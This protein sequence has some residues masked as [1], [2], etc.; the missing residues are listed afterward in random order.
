MQIANTNTGEFTP[1]LATESM[2]SS[3]SLLQSHMDVDNDNLAYIIHFQHGVNDCNGLLDFLKETFSQTV[4][5]LRQFHM[6]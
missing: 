2:C 4:L 1:N 3:T 5:H 6:H